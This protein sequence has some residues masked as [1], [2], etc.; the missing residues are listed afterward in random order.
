MTRRRVVVTGLGVVAPIGIGIEP[1]W[2][3]LI[4]GRSGVGPITAFDASPFKTRIAG[5]VKDFAAERYMS[6][7]TAKRSARFAQIGITAALEAFGHAGLA[8]VEGDAGARSAIVMGSGIGAF[9]MF[10]R[11]HES[12]IRRGPGKF[13]PLT[14]PMII[15]NATAG[16]LAGET[17]F[18]GPN[19]CVST[20][21]AT[22]A[23]A[24]G[25]AF[26]LVRAGRSDI[27]IAGSSEATVSPW[28]LD[29]YLQ[30]RA[31]SSRNDSP[32][33]ASR[34]FS[35]TRDGFVL[36]E[37]AGALILESLEHAQARGVPIHAELMGYGA[38][39]DGYHM[40]AP[41][42][43]N[44]GAV[45]AMRD[46]LSDAGLEPSDVDLVNAHGTS[47]PLND[48]AET[49]AIHKAFGSHARKLM[50]QS[51][52]SMTGH[53]IGGAAAIESVAGILQL[54]RGR[55]HPTIN[56]N[57]P[58]PECDLDYVPNVAREASPRVLMKN[59]FGFGGHNAVL[60]FRRWDG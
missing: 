20:A 26:D 35:A 6:P 15:P 47:T 19:F 34:P 11:E 4:H 40:T 2:E 12:F 23:T 56:L 8:P 37:G 29:G 42:P 41:D 59:A 21:C 60:V 14:V 9:D 27:A 3:S 49:A 1:F 18:R 5:E 43:T 28:A 10:E 32:E 30:L 57:D 17:G 46:A 24:I 33:T 39:A 31:L 13:H 54:M 25:A 45:R 50:V 51:T 22:G 16:A 55:V 44:Q 7:K 48:A 58:D 36:A 52:K 53:T 38:T